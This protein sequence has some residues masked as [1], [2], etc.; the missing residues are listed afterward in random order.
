MTSQG[1]DIV[2]KDEQQNLLSI[3][4]LFGKYA[5]ESFLSW[6]DL[7]HIGANNIQALIADLRSSEKGLSQKIHKLRSLQDL[8]FGKDGSHFRDLATQ[9]DNP[10]NIKMGYHPHSWGEPKE[11]PIDADSLIRNS[12][13]TTFNYCGWCEHSSAS[14][15]R[16]QYAVESH[17]KLLPEHFADWQE[18]V[19]FLANTPC[20]LYNH[21]AVVFEE[22]HSEYEREV[23]DL[24]ERREHIRRA[25]RQMQ[26]IK[27]G[28]EDKPYLM[29]LRP[30]DHF[31]LGDQIIG[32]VGGR[33]ELDDGVSDDWVT[34][35]VI[36][37]YRHQDGCVS[38]CFDQPI[39]KNKSYLDGA[40]SGYGM[41]RP[42]CLLVSTFYY[43]RNQLLQN[44]LI[45]IDLWMRSIYSRLEGFNEELFKK[46]LEMGT[47]LSFEDSDVS[48]VVKVESVK[49]AVSALNMLVPPKSRE[50]LDKW[51]HFMAS[52]V[53]PDLHAD[54]SEKVLAYLNRQ[55]AVYN[56][57]RD[58]LIKE[59]DL[60]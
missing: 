50:E 23:Q 58:L 41:S 51:Y 18:R 35:K 8:I 38:V 28:Q 52:E 47:I 4:D 56:Q 12:R 19:S 44:D 57:A 1:L 30:H 3:R 34:G 11:E 26:V 27:K 14:V 15:G 39:W 48:D 7:P 22:V 36:M 37:G 25:I 17:C 24:L 42:E 21:E 5:Q 20:R 29:S 55:M 16:Y 32:F 49:D 2:K 54:K 59:L 43:L 10:Q 33:D 9:Y 60:Q 13:T 46:A 6:E 31:N 53:H 40:G 45:F